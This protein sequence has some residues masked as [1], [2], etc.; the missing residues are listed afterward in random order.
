M[1][2]NALFTE[3]CEYEKEINSAWH[4]KLRSKRT[5]SLLLRKIE[6]EKARLSMSVKIFD[7]LVQTA[8]NS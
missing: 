1:T 7:C 6:H 4:W 3:L 2:A 5:K 8:E